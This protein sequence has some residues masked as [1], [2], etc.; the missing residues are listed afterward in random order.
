M[1]ESVDD[2]DVTVVHADAA[3]VVATYE[4]WQD[5]PA[6]RT[7]RRSTVLFERDAAARHGLRSKH[8]HETWISRGG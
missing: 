5:G 7:G 8:L 6:G 3:S 2:L 4:G 1:D